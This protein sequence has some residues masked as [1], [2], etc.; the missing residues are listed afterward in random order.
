[1]RHGKYQ[2]DLGCKKKHRETLMTNLASALFEHGRIKT[3]LAKA[4]ALR[5]F[6]EKLITMTAR[7]RRSTDVTEELHHR[8]V[9]VSRIH[10]EATSK[11]L[12][13]V[14]AVEFVN[15]QGGYTRIYKLIPRIG[16][17]AQMAIIELLYV[18]DRGYSKKSHRR[19]R[20]TPQRSEQ[21]VV[22][23][24]S[25]AHEHGEEAVEC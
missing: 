19:K 21:K 17:A 14:K 11:E 9:V 22:S 5:P 18:N 4:R 20:R 15:R 2:F 16:D 6:A 24:D 7:V 8:C 23:V 10:N 3:T 25:A 1:M 12:F 13:D